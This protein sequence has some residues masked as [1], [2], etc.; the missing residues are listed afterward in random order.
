MQVA[1]FGPAKAVRVTS[2]CPAG[3]FVRLA[4]AERMA[5]DEVA[6]SRVGVLDV[7]L[8]HR[9][10]DSPLAA[11]ADLDRR[12]LPA[13]PHECS[14][15]C[16][17][18]MFST[19]ATSDNSRN[20]FSP[21]TLLKL[22]QTLLST[23]EGVSMPSVTHWNA[24]VIH[25]TLPFVIASR[26]TR[27]TGGT[28]RGAVVPPSA[29]QLRGKCVRTACAVRDPSEIAVVA[30]R[31]ARDRGR[32]RA[33]L[34]CGGREDHLLVAALR[35]MGA[36]S[37]DIAPGTTLI[38]SDLVQVDVRFKDHGALYISAAGASP[39]GR[40]TVSPLASGQLIPLVAVPVYT[41]AG[42][43]ARDDSGRATA[44]A[45]RQRSARRAGRPLRH[46][47]DA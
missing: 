23:P 28:Q 26:T 2:L 6:G 25:T 18:E 13:R 37:R 15:A 29:H 14:Y 39:V 8:E 40:V 38:K 43:S 32:P 33:A 30:R 11:A 46:S 42:S 16:A 45:P 4:A 36:A 47:E 3:L 17:A 1:V 34:R 24:F 27:Q 10:L 20:R 41:A 12:S 35:L 19:S 9:H 44:Y 7:A 21:S 31:P 5:A 22:G